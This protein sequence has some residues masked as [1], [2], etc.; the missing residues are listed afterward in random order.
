MIIDQL[1]PLRPKDNKEVNAQVKHL[2]AMI[3]TAILVHSTLDCGERGWGR[4]A[5]H[6]QSPCGDLASSITPL[7]EHGGD[8]DNRDLC[9]FICNRDAHDKI[10]NWHQERDCVER[11]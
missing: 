8:R 1:T 11:E 10:E 6:H 3:D 5:D 7:E 9:D 4:D 2:Q